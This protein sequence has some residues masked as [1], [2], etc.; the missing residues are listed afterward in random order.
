MQ[1]ASIE[2]LKSQL[3]QLKQLHDTGALPQAEYQSSKAGLERRLVDLVLAAAG[4]GAPP[5]A[6]APTS[7]QVVPQAPAQHMSRA[8]T[9]AGVAN[10]AAAKL[11]ATPP[12]RRLLA[13]L[14]GLVLAVAAG[15]YALTGSPSLF[16]A[17]GPPAVAG[18]GARDGAAA[19]HAVSSDQ[20]AEMTQRLAARLKEQ[21]QDPQGWAMLGRSYSVLG[22]NDD[23]VQAYATAIAQ[24]GD[25]AALLADYADALAVKNNRVLA[26][27]PMKWVRRALEVDPKNVKALALAGT[28]AFDRK[29][30]AGAVKLWEK[31][32]EH[33]PNDAGFVEQVK[34]SIAEARERGGIAG[35]APRAAAP[36]APTAPPANGN[37]AAPKQ[38]AGLL[39]G[40]GV[41]GSVRLSAAL[42]AKAS[43]DDTV[44]IFA[45]AAEGSRM[46]LAVLRKRVR[47]LP[48]TFTL[49]DSLAMSP[50]AKISG[51]PQVIVG[52][53]ISKSGQAMATPG[54]LTGQVGPVALGSRSLTLEID[55]EVKP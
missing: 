2:T 31:L 11:G 20:I 24:Q 4:P 15:G 51:A 10:P 9:P 34:N 40:A 7:A 3:L 12:S 39:D 42:A 38:A 37:A 19:P 55:S 5:Q 14:G 41:S 43:P 27:E 26:G 49:D 8:A 17:S 52:A 22:R 6:V 25:D 46:P 29:D 45:R 18:A 48:A 33:G 1:E 44:F 50:A 28:D 47:D 36:A 53:R 35:A 13:V 23:A 54:D 21:P 16:V 32:L 30:F